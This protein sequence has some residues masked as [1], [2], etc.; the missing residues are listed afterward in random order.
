M[1]GFRLKMATRL[2][3]KTASDFG[4]ESFPICP[5]KIA[6][7]R[8]ISVE[9]KPPEVSGVSGA[10]ILA[11]DSAMIIYSTEL[12]NEG[13]ENFSIAHELGI[14]SCRAILKKLPKLAGCT[15]LGL[16]SL[17]TLPLNWRLIISRAGC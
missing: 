8:E 13:F 5:R 10:I 15:S 6:E 3:E 16:P 12:K 14:G 7:N 2:G 9:A 1:A 4:F 11:G 17:R